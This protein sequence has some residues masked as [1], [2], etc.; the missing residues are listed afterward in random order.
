M[1]AVIRGREALLLRYSLLKTTGG[2]RL[3]D[4]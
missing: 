4:K 2:K 3:I 1:R